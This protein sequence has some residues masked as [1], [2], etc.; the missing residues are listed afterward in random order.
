M[1]FRCTEGNNASVILSSTSP[2]YQHSSNRS[3]VITH[4]IVFAEVEVVAF[5]VS[6]TGAEVVNTISNFDII[7]GSLEYLPPDSRTTGEERSDDCL[8]FTLTPRDIR[9]FLT[10][11]AFIATF[12]NQL[13]NVLPNWLRFHST[14]TTVLGVN[15]LSTSLQRGSQIQKG[16]C[17]GAPLYPDHFYTVFK[18]GTE[19]SVSVYGQE[20]LLPELLNDKRFCVLVDICQDFGGAVFVVLPEES[21][22]ILDNFTLFKTL[23]HKYNIQIIPIGIGLSLAKRINAR[24]ENT[25]LQLW[26]GDELFEYQ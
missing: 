10:E 2:W 11:N 1:L 19:F 12:F 22:Y 13:E 7:T 8:S 15:E 5:P 25:E 23:M 4:G 17:R 6:L 16:V 9:D 18:F 21:R 3:R 14:G 20:V 24:S 26:K